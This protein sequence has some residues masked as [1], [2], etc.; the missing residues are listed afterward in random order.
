[1]SQPLPPYLSQQAQLY[2]LS[3]ARKTTVPTSDICTWIEQ[4]FLIPETPDH[5]FYLAPYQKRALTEAMRKDNN[6]NY[7]YSTVVWSDIKK[8]N[9]STIAAARGLYAAYCVDWGSVYAIA[10]DLKQADSRVAYYMRRAIE[11]NP[12]MKQECKINRYTITLPNQ[13]RI[14]AIPVDPTGEAGGNADCLIFSELWGWKHAA[15]IR[16]WTE[17]TLSPTKFGRSQRWA[18][19]YAG[20]IGESPILEML[21]QAGVVNGKRIDEDVEL[22]A[23]GSLLVLW[24]TRPRLEWQTP[25][26]YASESAILPPMEFDRIHRNKWAQSSDAFVPVEWW[27]ACKQPYPQFNHYTPIVI[28]LDAAISGDSFAMIGI[29]RVGGKCYIRFVHIWYPPKNGKIDFDEPRKQ[30]EHYARNYNVECCTY[31]PYQLEYFASLMSNSG[32]VYMRPFNQGVERLESDT[33]LFHAIRER[34]IIHD[35]NEELTMHVMNSNKEM[36]GTDDRKMR[37]VKRHENAKIDANVATSMAHKVACD[38][39]LG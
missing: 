26:Y 11:L 8:S 28:G 10:N 2:R 22:Y 7:V 39:Q 29:S 35:G 37:I 31:D 21:Y 36:T 13:S 33:M 27:T 20:E 6:G 34:N 15:H 38:L 4:N 23:N 9:K 14:E 24:N 5:H 17:Q 12:S 19:G 25:E 32:V 18:E 3:K 30:L 16:M 1:M